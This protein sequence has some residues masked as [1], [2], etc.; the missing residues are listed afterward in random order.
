LDFDSA[1]AE[2]GRGNWL[3]EEEEVEMVVMVHE[4]REVAGG[5]NK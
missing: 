5:G 1:E 4:E 3:G 2:E